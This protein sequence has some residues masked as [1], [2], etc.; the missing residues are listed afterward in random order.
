MDVI[1]SFYAGYGDFGVDQGKIMLE[2]EKYLGKFP[3]LDYIRSC[4]FV[5]RGD[6]GTSDQESIA[7]SK[8]AMKEVNSKKG[9]KTEKEDEDD[10]LDIDF[11]HPEDIKNLR[12]HPQQQATSPQEEGRDAEVEDFAREREQRRKDAEDARQQ[13]KQEREKNEELEREADEKRKQK[14]KEKAKKAEKSKPKDDLEYVNEYGQRVKDLNEDVRQTRLQREKRKRQREE[15]KRKEREEQEQAEK[16]AHGKEEQ[17]VIESNLRDDKT[18]RQ[19]EKSASEPKR[20]VSQP[21]SKQKP[22]NDA[23]ASQAVHADSHGHYHPHPPLKD[24]ALSSNNAQKDRDVSTG[25]AARDA[26][27]LEAPDALRIRKNKGKSL[28]LPI[29]GFLLLLGVAAIIVL[30]FPSRL[31]KCRKWLKRRNVTR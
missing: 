2:G 20:E 31:R 30:Q 8:R 27:I 11:F 15:Q 12:Q 13:A 7:S 6:A 9:K 1:R 19:Q 4:E 17:G 14:E 25:N 16:V 23:V 26:Q 21:L 28:I 18:Q 3:R 22:R 5:T 24:P 29:G 10:Y